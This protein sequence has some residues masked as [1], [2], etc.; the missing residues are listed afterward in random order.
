[1]SLIFHVSATSFTSCKLGCCYIT[2]TLMIH[3]HNNYK[4]KKV[5]WHRAVINNNNNKL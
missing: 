2:S 3:L 4:I 1:M 5:N